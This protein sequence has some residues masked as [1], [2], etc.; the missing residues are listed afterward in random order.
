MI[1]WPQWTCFLFV[2]GLL[3][4]SAAG[5]EASVPARIELTVVDPA[6]TG[7]ATFQSHN[8]KVIANRRGLFMTHL[9]TRNEA[10]TA[11]QWRL[12]WST[13][14]GRSFKTIHESTDATN[15]PVIESDDADNLYVVRPDFMDGH[16]YLYRFASTNDY[17]SPRITRIPHGAAGKYAMVF[18]RSRQQLCYFAHNNSFHLVD[19]DG[20]VR[21]STNLLKAGTS[22]ILQYPLL[23][24]DAN[25]VLHA[26]WTSQKHGV[27]LYWDI[28]Y[29]QSADGGRHW[30]TMSGQSVQTPAI[31]DEGGPTDRITL[32]DEFSV[33]TWL[34]SFLI[35]DGKAHFLYLAQTNP[36]RQ[37]YVRYDLTTARRELDIQPEFKGAQ[38]SLRG[39]DGFFAAPSRGAPG[40]VY[41]VGR[42][43]HAS[44][45]VCLASRDHGRTWHDHAVSASVTNPYSIGGCRDVTDDGWIIGSFT[46]QSGSTTDPGG[47]SR[48]HF[49]RIP[50]AFPN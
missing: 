23:H 26:A 28:H 40:V 37:H 27:Y 48:V 16:A 5:P 12:S 21:Y 24:L 1:N 44:R 8:Q 38:L 32:D 35:R 7:Y 17:R 49:F 9:R 20:Q 33:H 31:A 25:H 14:G 4:A 18:D 42:D 6:A 39:L 34:S 3:S 22:A 30:R 47:G 29:L 10:Y 50:A 46:E 15:P 13:N 19:L 11:Q 43:A 36:P 45:L 2:C 41:C